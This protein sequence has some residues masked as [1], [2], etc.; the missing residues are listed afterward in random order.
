MSVG[1]VMSYLE[2]RTLLKFFAE[3]VVRA[4]AHPTLEISCGPETSC[5]PPRSKGTST[6][7]RVAVA[8]GR[9]PVLDTMARV[10]PEL[11]SK[12]FQVAAGRSLC[13][14]AYVDNIYTMAWPGNDVV[15]MARCVE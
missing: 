5:I 2:L 6:G 3:A 13:I 4:Q 1:K 10:I 12:G 14:G 8:L 11:K 15:A 7:S 9:I